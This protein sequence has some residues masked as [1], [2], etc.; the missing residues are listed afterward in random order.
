VASSLARITMASLI[1]GLAAWGTDHAI[2]A[3]LP[4][5]AIPVLLLR[6]GAAIGVALVVL[7]VA[8]RALG[9]QEFIEARA[10]VLGR[11]ARLRKTA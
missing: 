8:A 7:D 2:A 11:L 3:W 9:V 1:M 10:M 6:V 4:S 5:H